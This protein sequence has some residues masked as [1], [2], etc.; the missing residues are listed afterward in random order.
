MNDEDEDGGDPRGVTHSEHGYRSP[1]PIPTDPPPSFSDFMDLDIRDQFAYTKPVMIAILNEQYAPAQK[2]HDMFI[3]GGQG[4][5]AVVDD[6]GLRGRMDPQ[7]VSELQNYLSEWCLRDERRAQVMVDT[8]EPGATESEDVVGGSGTVSTD[9][10]I[11]NHS[12]RSVSPVRSE[13]DVPP[14]SSFTPELTAAVVGVASPSVSVKA[15]YLCYYSE[16]LLQ[17]LNQLPVL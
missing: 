1:S 15:D 16:H 17:K 3:G 5:K 6:A 14:P 12:Q 10:D 4:R 7:S 13:G 8:G 9:V 2:K 11:D